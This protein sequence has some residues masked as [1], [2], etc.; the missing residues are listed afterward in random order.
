MGK[1]KFRLAFLVQYCHHE[2]PRNPA[3]FLP[4]NEGDKGV[5]LGTRLAVPEW[6]KAWPGKGQAQ[7][8]P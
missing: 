5:K 7:G 2:F 6:S 1:G 3:P 8:R 4:K